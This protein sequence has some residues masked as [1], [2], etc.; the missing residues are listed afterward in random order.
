MKLRAVML[1][2]A[3]LAL[4]TSPVRAQTPCERVDLHGLFDTVSA[5][6][7]TQDIGVRVRNGSELNV[8]V[9]GWL[10]PERPLGSRLAVA[11]QVGGVVRDCYDGFAALTLVTVSFSGSDSTGAKVRFVA[12][13]RPIQL[14][15]GDTTQVMTFQSSTGS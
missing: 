2:V 8:E 10:P 13:F 5:M 14:V 3:L 9:A 1:S 4:G 15:P 12:P 7:S 6:L 11:R